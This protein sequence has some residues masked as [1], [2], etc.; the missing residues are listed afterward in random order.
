MFKIDD[1]YKKEFEESRK[2]IEKTEGSIDECEARLDAL[3]NDS[4]FI[5]LMNQSPNR[6]RFFQNMEKAWHEGGWSIDYVGGYEQY[7][8]DRDAF[9]RENGIDKLI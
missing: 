2:R 1:R 4:E 7:V 3:Q 6:F 8:K 5:A 9:M